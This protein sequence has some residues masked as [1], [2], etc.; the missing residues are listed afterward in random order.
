MD[1]LFNRMVP[2]SDKQRFIVGPAGKTYITGLA[3]SY[4]T[5]CYLKTFFEKYG[6]TEH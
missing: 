3:S 1:P 6:I 4:D 5:E 2:K